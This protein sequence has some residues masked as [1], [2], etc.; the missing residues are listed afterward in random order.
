LAKKLK[1]YQKNYRGGKIE[2]S[3]FSN[4]LTTWLTSFIKSKMK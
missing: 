1:L 4:L 2:L 3:K